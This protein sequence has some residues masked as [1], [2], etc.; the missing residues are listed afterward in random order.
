MPR[1]Y[2]LLAVL[3]LILGACVTLP[4]SQETL[5]PGAFP[6]TFAAA[7]LAGTQERFVRAVGLTNHVAYVGMWDASDGGPRR[8]YIQAY[9]YPQGTYGTKPPDFE[10]YFPK[11]EPAFQNK[12]LRFEP[13]KAL[14]GLDGIIYYRAFSDGAASCVAF[15]EHI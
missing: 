6:I 12:A 7:G 5:D 9:H 13:V 10:E 4:S 2:L 8:A 11:F 15:F 3:G 1:P 14:L